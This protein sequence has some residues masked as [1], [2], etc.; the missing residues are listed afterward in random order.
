MATTEHPTLNDHT[1]ALQPNYPDLYYKTDRRFESPPS[2]K[3]YKQTQMTFGTGNNTSSL[4]NVDWAFNGAR[5]KYLTHGLHYYPARMI[6]QIP[7]ALLGFWKE[8]GVLEDGDTV[9]DPFCGSGTTPTE[10]RLHGLNAVAT[11]INPFACLLARGKSTD[12]DLD[13]LW[14][15]AQRC[16]G[17]NWRR[18]EQ[19]IDET[20]EDEI[21]NVPTEFGNDVVPE[22]QTEQPSYVNEGWFPHLQ[23]R[24]I[25]SMKRQISEL[26]GEY[27][28]KEARIVRISLAETARQIS[29]QRDREFKR[30]RMC[31]EDREDHNPPFTNTFIDNLYENV[32][33]IEA[34]QNHVD[35]NTSVEI[36][37]ADCR[38]R[39]IIE[40]DSTDAVVCSPPYGDSSTTVAYGQFS[41]DPAA[42]ATPLKSEWMKDVDPSGLGGRLSGHDLSMDYVTRWSPTLKKTLDELKSVDG[43][44]SDVLDFFVDYSQTL[45]QMKRVVKPGQPVAI[46]VGNRTVSRIPIP[47]NLITTEIA[48][49]IGLEHSHSLPREI[50]SKT[51]PYANAPENVPGHSGKLIAGEYVL[52]FEA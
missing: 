34:Y 43:R 23:L 24:K 1:Q 7:R 18:R 15:L 25:E 14:A 33:R 35:A 42:T 2:G 37:H 9:F 28:H 30:H 47:L 31:E 11:D 6:P 52:I 45:I 32:L 44:D 10:A 12:V 26:R 19:F 39:D 38:D 41:R 21:S 3:A 36:H 49:E 4:E 20:Y 22:H 8:T 50:P 17:A 46:V 16:I 51:L 48:L 29:Y 5:T 40:A 13:A 27:G